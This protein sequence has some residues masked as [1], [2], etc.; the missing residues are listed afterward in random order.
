[1]RIWNKQKREKE[2]ETEGRVFIGS[3]CTIQLQ[4]SLVRVLYSYSLILS[5]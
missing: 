3:L 2:S 4:E 5:V 1:M